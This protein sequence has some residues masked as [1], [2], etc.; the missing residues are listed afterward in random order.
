MAK[1]KN[2]NPKIVDQ[3]VRLEFSFDAR[4]ISDSD[5]EA[6]EDIKSAFINRLV[7]KTDKITTEMQEEVAFALERYVGVS[8]YIT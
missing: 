2:K 5:K 7:E 1:R 8:V 4:C 3:N 6:I